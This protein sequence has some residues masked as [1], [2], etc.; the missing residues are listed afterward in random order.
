MK[1]DEVWLLEGYHTSAFE[2]AVVTG[3]GKR[4]QGVS[5]VPIIWQTGPLAGRPALVERAQFS[6]KLK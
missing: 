2:R 6:E 4:Y 1:K 5:L 3:K